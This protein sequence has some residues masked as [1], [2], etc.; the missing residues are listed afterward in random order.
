MVV[1]SIAAAAE[2]DWRA[3]AWLLERRFPERWGKTSPRPADLPMI[4]PPAPEPEELEDDVSP[5]DALDE[6]APRRASR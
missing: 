4:P 2:V 3:G 1:S 6:L 5:F